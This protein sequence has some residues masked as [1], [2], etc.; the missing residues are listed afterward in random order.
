MS[1]MLARPIWAALN[2]RQAERA[3]TYEMGEFFGI[4]V[5]GRL[6]AMA[7]ERMK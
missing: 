6:A 5:D 2:S 7:G 3:R 1:I 4:C